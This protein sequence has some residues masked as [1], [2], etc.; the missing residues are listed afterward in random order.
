MGRSR[1]EIQFQHQTVEVRPLSTLSDPSKRI[2]KMADFKQN[3]KTHFGGFYYSLGSLAD[4][5]VHYRGGL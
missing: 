4:L 3:T 5:G 1:H 2:F